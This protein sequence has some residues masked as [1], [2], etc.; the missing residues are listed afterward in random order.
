MCGKTIEFNKFGN[1]TDGYEVNAK[2]GEHL[3]ALAE[4]VLVEIKP[5]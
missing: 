5:R 2:P 1:F 3:F 4:N